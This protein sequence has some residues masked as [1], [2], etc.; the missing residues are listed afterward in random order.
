MTDKLL[1]SAELAE[2]WGVHPRHPANLRLAGRGPAYVRLGSNVRYRLSEVIRH[3]NANT[4]DTK[5]AA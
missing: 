4:V 1:T 5:V 3:E 2:R